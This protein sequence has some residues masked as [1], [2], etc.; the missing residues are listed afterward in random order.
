MTPV[1][2]AFTGHVPR[3]TGT[4]RRQ[5]PARGRGW[6]RPSSTRT[7]RSSARSPPSIVAAPAGAVRHRPPVRGRPVH[8]DGAGRHRRDGGYPAAVAAAIVDGLRRRGS[9]RGLG[10]A[11]VAVLVPGRL[12]DARARHAVRR[13]RSPP[14]G[15]W[16]STCGPRPTRMAATRRLRRATV[17]LERS[18]ELRRTQRAHRRPGGHRRRP[19]S[20]ARLRRGRRSGSASR[21]RRSTTT[22]AFFELIADRAWNCRP[23]PTGSTAGSATFGPQRYGVGRPGGRRRVER[24]A[25]ARCSTST[26]ALDLPRA[27]HLARGRDADY[28][29]TLAPDSTMRRRRARGTVLRPGRRH[30]R[31]PRTHP[32]AWRS[33]RRGDPRRRPRR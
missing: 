9:R 14:A 32:R 3:R 4:A 22:P 30:R 7:T 12:L 1:L 29:A 31:G 25:A 33:T 16:S 8:R 28:F 26:A 21:W 20:G 27:I 6:R 2:P 17:D 15:C 10:A 23:P 13:R 11:V 18:A 5:A 19:R 24:A